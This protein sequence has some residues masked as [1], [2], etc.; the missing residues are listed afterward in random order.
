MMREMLLK[1]DVMKL[2]KLLEGKSMIVVR[3]EI[4][5]RVWV[6]FFD[7]LGYF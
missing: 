1:N 6:F 2:F 5:L 7:E 3:D 4:M